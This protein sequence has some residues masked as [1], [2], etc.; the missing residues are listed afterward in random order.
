MRALPLS[1]CMYRNKRI[2]SAAIRRGGCALQGRHGLVALLE[3]GDGLR[4]KRLEQLRI[5]IDQLGD[6]LEAGLVPLALLARDFGFELVHLGSPPSAMTMTLSTAPPFMIGAYSSSSERRS[7]AL[8]LPGRW[9]SSV[10]G[11]SPSAKTHCSSSA[12]T[13]FETQKRMRLK[14]SGSCAPLLI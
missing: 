12:P 2:D 6:P 8:L 11:G 14:V 5:E 7:V 3:D 4:E 13:M 10:R 1:V 9:Y